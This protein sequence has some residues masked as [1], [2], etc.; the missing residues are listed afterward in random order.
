MYNN[1]TEELTNVF[2]ERLC[3]IWKPWNKIYQN[4]IKHP[5]K[6]QE[7][8]S[9]HLHEINPFAGEF[10]PCIQTCNGTHKIG[11]EE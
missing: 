5:N 2:G 6:E 10:G 7:W 8:V 11:M 1:T 3:R 9:N 4:V